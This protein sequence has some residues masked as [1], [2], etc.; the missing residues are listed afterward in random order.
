M[1]L[2]CKRFRFV[3]Y[4][5]YRSSFGFLLL[6]AKS[7]NHIAEIFL[8]RIWQLN[9]T[10]RIYQCLQPSQTLSAVAFENE[11][12]K[13][14]IHF[15]WCTCNDC[16]RFCRFDFFSFLFLVFLIS[17]FIASLLFFALPLYE[18]MAL[19]GHFGQSGHI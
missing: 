6:F 13:K 17:L 2:L 11:Q 5:C 8:Q 19:V 16:F 1:C 10:I 14:N 3:V 18:S 7:H 9:L 15:H 4:Y 12:K